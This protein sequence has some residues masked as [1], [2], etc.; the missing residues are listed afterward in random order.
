MYLLD[1]N[2]LIALAWDDHVH[3]DRAHLWFGKLGA[4]PFAT[5]NTT[6]SGFVRVSFNRKAM[7]CSLGIDEIFTKLESFTHHAMHQFWEDG[8]L[9]TQASVWRNI[10]SHKQVTDT[11]LASISHQRRG[12]LA[13]LDE[14]IKSK[15][16]VTERAWVE[17][18]PP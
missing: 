6:Q 5:C 15:L 1:V 10:T 4:T 8:P 3:H 11:N 12:K 17:V 9:Q 13:T 14:G 18:I 16:T 2:L 7:N